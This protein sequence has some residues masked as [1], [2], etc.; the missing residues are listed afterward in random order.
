MMRSLLLLLA[1]SAASLCINV[2]I[3]NNC[4]KIVRPVVQ[5]WVEVGGAPGDV[6]Q[7]VLNAGQKATFTYTLSTID[8]KNGAN[9]KNFARIVTLSDVPMSMYMIDRGAGFDTGMRI[10]ANDA[11]LVPPINCQQAT[12]FAP[13]TMKSNAVD[14][15]GTFIIT[16]CP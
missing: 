1:F 4:K 7:E 11:T 6:H 13:Q 15:V 16:F 5:E 3:K 14:Y 9:G 10:G 8:V 2:T 12:C